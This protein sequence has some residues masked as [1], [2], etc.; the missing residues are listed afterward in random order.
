[1]NKSKVLLTGV[2]GFLGSHTAIELLNR[3]YQV[4]GSLRDMKRADAIQHVIAKHT[5]SINNLSFVQ[6]DLLDK[7]AW[8]KACKNQDF[9][10]HA[11]S[12]FPRELPKDEHELIIPAKEGTLNVLQAAKHNH[13]KRVVLVSSI[14]TV[15]YGKQTDE[16]DRVFTEEHWTDESNKQDTAPY[17]RSKTIAEKAAWNFIKEEG[18]GMELV[19]IL[20]GA[21]L[22]PVLEEDYGTSANIIVKILSGSMPA[23]PKIGFEIVDVRSVAKLLVDA[24]ELE[25]AA[26]NRYMASEGHMSM[27]ELAEVLKTHFPDRKISTANLPNFLA[28]IMSIFEPALKPVLLDLGLKRKVDASKAKRELGWKGHSMEKAIL[29]CANSV[30][31]LGIVK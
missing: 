26:G 12:P 22:G 21:M 13:V 19:S 18:K 9:V 14:S 24:M 23:M 5:Q 3:G 27:K 7:G 8:L 30:I 28:R 16:M 11:A 25:N 4:T 29:D 20:P 31:E 17:M 2:T 10:I 6:A 15:V 1:M